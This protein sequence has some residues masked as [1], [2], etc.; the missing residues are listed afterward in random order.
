ML[1]RSFVS[2]LEIRDELAR[3][4]LAVIDVPDVAVVNPIALYTRRDEPLPPA[5]RLCLDHILS[6]F[7]KTG[8]RSG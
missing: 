2:A 8:C 3:G 4:E 5:A 7:G 1:F 6:A